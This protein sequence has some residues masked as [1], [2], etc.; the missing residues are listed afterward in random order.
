MYLQMKRLLL[1]TTLLLMSLGALAQT[2][3]NGLS[4]PSCTPELDSLN[5]C[6]IREAY[7]SQAG[8]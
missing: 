6:R 8:P 3:E 7:S 1:L 4:L 2:A 5:M